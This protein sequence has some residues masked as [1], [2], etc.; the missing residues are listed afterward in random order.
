MDHGAL[1]GKIITY[2]GIILI[3]FSC[4]CFYCCCGICLQCSQTA[5]KQAT[6]M[7]VKLFLTSQG[8]SRKGPCKIIRASQ[9]GWSV[10]GGHQEDVTTDLDSGSWRL[11]TPPLS[12][13]CIFCSLLPQWE[14]DT[15]HSL[16]RPHPTGN[17][18]IDYVTEP[19][20]AYV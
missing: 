3:F 2:L 7:L 5:A 18:W 15:G 10:G 20:K 14:V 6:F 17:T 1:S 9:E 4:M 8:M 13:E 11:F 19:I 12:L 16:E